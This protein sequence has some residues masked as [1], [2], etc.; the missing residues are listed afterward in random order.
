VAAAANT[1]FRN[2]KAK[3]IAAIV[4]YLGGSLGGEAG[5]EYVKSRGSAGLGGDPFGIAFSRQA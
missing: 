1:P 5:R 2:P 3:T 4:G